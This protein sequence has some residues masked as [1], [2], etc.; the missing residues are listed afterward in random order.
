M[1]IKISLP[2]LKNFYTLF[3]VKSTLRDWKKKFT[4]F[5]VKLKFKLTGFASLL[6]SPGW[7]EFGVKT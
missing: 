3:D 4:V 2:D 7:V 1:C 6:S 5:L